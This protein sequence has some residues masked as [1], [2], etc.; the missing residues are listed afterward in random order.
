MVMQN[1]ILT[2][3]FIGFILLPLYIWAKPKPVELMLAKVAD[4]T[5]MFKRPQVY[6]LS[7]KYDGVRAY[8][9][10][11]QFLT[12]RGNKI[13]SPDWFTQPLPSLPLDGELWIARGQFDA[14]S[15]AIRTLSP[16][17]NELLS[18]KFMV[19]DSPKSLL[20]FEFRQTQIRQVVSSINV[21]WVKQVKQLK[22]ENESE[23][24]VIFQQIVKAGGEGVMLNLANSYYYQGR[25]DRLLKLKPH[26]DAEAKVLKHLAGRG[27]FSGLMGAILVRNATGHVFKIGSGFSDSERAKPPL[28]GSTITYRFSGFTNSGKPRFATFVRQYNDL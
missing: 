16:D 22:V 17:D 3:L 24:N 26:F 18:I 8:W 14:V 19:F 27:K 2:C 20:P 4:V 28:V 1:F 23:V 9:D 13:H 12:R 6:W 7:E 21:S 5:H 15:G 10:G 11:K 25:S